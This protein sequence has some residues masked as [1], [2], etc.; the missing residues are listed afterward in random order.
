MP[1][2]PETIPDDAASIG[3][4]GYMRAW[5]DGNRIKMKFRNIP[6]VTICFDCRAAG[7]FAEWLQR[8]GDVVG[9][10]IFSPKVSE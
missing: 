5:R 9:E 7:D 4:N 2:P 8:N 6:Q 3:P 1:V 10:P